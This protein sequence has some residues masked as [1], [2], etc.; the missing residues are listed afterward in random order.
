[1]SSVCLSVC[2]SVTLV[3]QDHIG[4]KSCKL[5]A[6][7]ISPTSS[8]FVAH[9]PSTYS[10]GNM[11]KFGET[12]GGVEK[13]ACW[14]TKAAIYLKRVKIDEK[15][16][17]RA[18]RNSATLFRT[19]PSPTPLPQDWGFAT[20]PHNCNRYYLKNGSSYGLQIWPIYS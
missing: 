6:R 13:V 2:L 1:M 3:D 7:T 16:L 14:S 17:W 8:L 5:T 15:L 10:R 11:A 19:V 20:P 9:R 4:W 18:Y 12:G